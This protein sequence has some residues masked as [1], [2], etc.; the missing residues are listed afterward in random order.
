MLEPDFMLEGNKGKFLQL[1]LI[2]YNQEGEITVCSSHSPE[3]AFWI[4]EKARAEMMSWGT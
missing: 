4:L 1:V 3:R 2:G